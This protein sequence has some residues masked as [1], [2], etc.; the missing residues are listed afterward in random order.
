MADFFRV[1]HGDYGE[2]NSGLNNQLGN[3]DTIMEG[4]NATLSRIS[5]A[6]GGKAT[7][8][9]LEQQNQWNR[10]YADMHTQLGVH[11]TNSFK[12]GDNFLEGDNQGYRVMS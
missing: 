5:E 10:A 6:S 9:W 11:T 1:N 3:L 12:V 7:P 8:L 4:L 2:V